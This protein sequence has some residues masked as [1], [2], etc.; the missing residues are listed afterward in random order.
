LTKGHFSQSNDDSSSQKSTKN[1]SDARQA[2]ARISPKK[3]A[4]GSLIFRMPDEN[5]GIIASGQ[6]VLS[7]PVLTPL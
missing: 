1:P 2:N 3:G 4:T 7:G 5:G 6:E